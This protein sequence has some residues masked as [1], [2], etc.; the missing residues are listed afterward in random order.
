MHFS[1][2]HGS[3]KLCSLSCWQ[4][5]KTEA[6]FGLDQASCLLG[7]LPWCLHPGTSTA[8]ASKLYLTSEAWPLLGKSEEHSSRLVRKAGDGPGRC[9]SPDSK[10]EKPSGASPA[11]RNQSHS[12]G[13][14][15]MAQPSLWE[16]HTAF[17]PALQFQGQGTYCRLTM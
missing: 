3:L 15:T 1:F 10:Q 13:A 14:S 8:R 2:C 11:L 5:G 12:A 4:G 17:L 16:C 7:C 9:S 6:C